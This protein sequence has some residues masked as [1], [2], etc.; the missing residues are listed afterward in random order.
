MRQTLATVLDHVKYD[1]L[2][3]LAA[4]KKLFIANIHSYIWNFIL[5]ALFGRHFF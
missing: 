5:L 3:N 2:R 1:T 4:Q